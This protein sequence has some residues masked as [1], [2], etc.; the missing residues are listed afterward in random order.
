MIEYIKSLLMAIEWAP[1]NVPLKRRYQVLS[2]FM[3]IMIVLIGEIV[4]VYVMYLLLVRF[5][6]LSILSTN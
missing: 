3:Y 4:C 6:N 2:A 5:L 1:L